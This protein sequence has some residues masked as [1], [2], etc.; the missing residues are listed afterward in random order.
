MNRINA[1]KKTNNETILVVRFRAARDDS[2]TRALRWL[3]KVAGRR[4]HLKCLS[5]VEEKA[6][7]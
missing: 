1:E 3:L 5:V 7:P 2:S 4:F 6:S